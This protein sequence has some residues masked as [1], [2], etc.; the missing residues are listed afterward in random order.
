MM[1]PMGHPTHTRVAGEC[2]Y[3]KYVAPELEDDSPPLNEF[4]MY[5]GPFTAPSDGGGDPPPKASSTAPPSST[6]P[7]S[8]T[9]QISL[10]CEACIDKL[11]RG[12]RQHSRVKGQCD[13]YRD[14][15]PYMFFK[16]GSLYQK[17]FYVMKGPG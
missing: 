10:R 15:Y 7:P 13:Y 1:R 12:S 16:G 14:V 5:H 6:V 17:E 4:P 2:K 9:P 11:L 8:S 3:S